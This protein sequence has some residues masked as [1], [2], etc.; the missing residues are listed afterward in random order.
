MLAVFSLW[1]C[2]PLCVS[3]YLERVYHAP[4][5]LLC[6]TYASGALGFALSLM[7]GGRR[8]NL[9]LSLIGMFGSTIAI[10]YSSFWWG[11]GYV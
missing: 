10:C 9:V 7:P 4:A 8:R 3:V 2:L 5:E 1:H 6:A 11:A